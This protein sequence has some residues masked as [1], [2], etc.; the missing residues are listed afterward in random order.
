MNAGRDIRIAMALLLPTVV[1]RTGTLFLERGKRRAVHRMIEH[2]ERRL[3]GWTE[4][5]AVE[6]RLQGAAQKCA[7]QL[8]IFQ[9]P[10]DTSATQGAVAAPVDVI[11]HLVVLIEGPQRVRI[12]DVERADPL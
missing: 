7:E 8:R 4:A 3:Q 12:V 1:A 5:A 10:A 6:P 2:I 11:D 9:D